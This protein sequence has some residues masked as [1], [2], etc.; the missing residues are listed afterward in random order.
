MVSPFLPDA[1][2]LAAVRAALPAT[3]AGIYLNT[4]TSGPLPAETHAAMAQWSDHELR[5]GR[6]NPADFPEILARVDETRATIAALLGSDPDRIA[7]THSTSHGMNFASFAPDWRAG[8]STVTSSEEHPG[9]LGPLQVL[10]DEWGVELR[11]VEL[12]ER[13]DDAI[14][15]GFERAIDETTRLVSVS[16]VSWMTGRI[17]PVARIAAVARAA[18][19]LVAVDGAQS[20]GAIRVEPDRLGVDFY[21]LPGQKWLLGPEGTG[22]MWVSERATAEARQSAAGYFSFEAPAEGRLWSTARRF[23]VAG[24]NWGLTFGLARSVGWLSMFV[25]L[26]WV[27]SRG[28][29]MAARARELLGAIDGV[30]ILTPRDAAGPLVA[31]RIAGWTCEEALAELGARCFLIGR[32]IAPL[33][34]L[35]VSPAFFTTE[36]ELLTLAETVEFVAGHRPDTI[37]PRRSLN[38]LA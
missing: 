17:L 28:A 1:E 22:A 7:L 29:A 27:Y 16:H 15:A 34:A 20:A 19:A 21:A 37:P 38:V 10:R 23:E 18:G 26:D 8:G 30:E 25:G 4:G 35:R 32:T 11:T 6:A 5:T 24:V 31:F 14:V 9:G 3:A 12:G 13:D 2:R 33:G 36:D